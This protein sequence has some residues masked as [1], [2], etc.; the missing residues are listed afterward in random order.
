M[1]MKYVDE[2]GGL[3]RLA[4]PDE[5]R[6]ALGDSDDCL[7]HELIGRVGAEATHEVAIDLEIVERE[8]L[9][10]IERSEPGTEVVQRKAAAER[11][12]SDAP[13]APPSAP[14]KC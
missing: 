14:R 8:M 11:S 9:E 6:I 12:P 10:V 1:M 13:S 5:V 4:T 7:D 2:I 3:D